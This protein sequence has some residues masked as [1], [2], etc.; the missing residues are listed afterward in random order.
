MPSNQKVIEYLNETSMVATCQLKK[1]YVFF[2]GRGVLFNCYGI[3]SLISFF[4]VKVE[5]VTV[6]GIIT[7]S[8]TYLLLI[9]L[10]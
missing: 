10:Q 9:I 8:S 2:A 1:L 3:P 6:G 4:H 5:G 7:T